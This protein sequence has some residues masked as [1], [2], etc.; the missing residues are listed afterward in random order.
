MLAEW[1]L[2]CGGVASACSSTGAAVAK[3]A[4]RMLKAAYE[5]FSLRDFVIIVLA[6]QT[7]ISV[8]KIGSY[9][10]AV[11]S[12]FQQDPDSPDAEDFVAAA[13]E[14]S[15]EAVAPLRSALGLTRKAARLIG[16]IILRE[17][18]TLASMALGASIIPPIIIAAFSAPK[19]VYAAGL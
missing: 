19:G 10:S 18:A 9:V 12:V 11:L 13:S 17:L 5:S 4:L 2:L 7:L 3:A 8:L 14:H 16:S 6:L 1:K 15:G